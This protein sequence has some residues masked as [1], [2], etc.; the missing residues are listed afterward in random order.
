MRYVTLYFFDVVLNI[1][2]KMV[3][4]CSI[5]NLPETVKCIGIRRNV[6]IQKLKCTV[7]P[8]EPDKCKYLDDVFYPFSFFS[9]VFFFKIE[10]PIIFII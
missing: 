9:F 2:V 6:L 7:A 10:S 3:D 5:F 1:G 8:E 4:L